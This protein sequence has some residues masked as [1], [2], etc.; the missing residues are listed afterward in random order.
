VRNFKLIWNLDYLL[1]F[2]VVF[3]LEWSQWP[4]GLRNEL[5]SPAQTLGSWV[6]IP[7]ETWMSV[8]AYSVSVLFCARIAALRRAD[9]PSKESYRLCKKGQGKKKAANAQQRTVELQTDALLKGCNIPSLQ[10]TIKITGKTVAVL[11]HHGMKT[12]GGV[13]I[14]LCHS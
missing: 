3:G 2:T 12:Y 14:Q 6:R 10:M 4:R 7:L 5:S 11:K 9:L 8:C 1:F 13:E